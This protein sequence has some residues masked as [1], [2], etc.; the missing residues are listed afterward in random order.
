MELYSWIIEN[1]ELIK[2]FYGLIVGI[3]C[4]VIVSK[5][6][7]LYHLSFHEGI[8]YFRNAFLF[9]G[10]AFIIRYVLG[11]FTFFGLISPGYAEMIRVL[12]EFFLVMAGFFL[13]YSLLWNKIEAGGMGNFSSILNLRILIFYIMAFIITLLDYLWGNYYFMFFSQIIIF[14]I[15]SIVSYVN[16]I[17]NGKKR[18]FLKF[19][20]IAMIL[21][22]VAWV[23]NAVTALY[24]DWNRG[25]L[26]Y[27]YFLNIVIFL[28][29][30]FGIIWITRKPGRV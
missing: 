5:S 19:Y 18:K 12:F 29:F 4:L 26:V 14:I 11:G 3:I 17:K 21:A 13:L 30:L 28:L 27:V 9:F 23:L 8:R 22:L 24:F 15:A 7:K 25:V 2:L 16:Y 6:H 1:K 20:F 10:I